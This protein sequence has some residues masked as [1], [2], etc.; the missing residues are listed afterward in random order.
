MTWNIAQAKQQFSE[1]VRLSAQEPQVIYN[2]ERRVAAVI[3]A[4]TFASFE[5]WCRSS[6]KKTLGAE[7]DGLRRIAVEENYGLPEMPRAAVARANAFATVL[8]EWEE[9]VH[10][11]A[12]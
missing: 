2:R 3:D 11:P 6:R 9:T 4:D 12:A 1:V 8:E 10:E 7:F 5:E